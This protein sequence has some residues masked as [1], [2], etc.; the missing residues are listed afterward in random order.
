MS[1]KKLTNKWSKKS[2]RSTGWTYKT[3]EVIGPFF[4]NARSAVTN[5]NSQSKY[6]DQNCPSK[7]DLPLLKQCLTA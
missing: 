6:S 4:R 2:G 3:K 5:T 7:Q 1:E